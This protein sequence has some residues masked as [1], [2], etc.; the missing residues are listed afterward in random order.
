MNKLIKLLN[1]LK[2]PQK[3]VQVD[4]L[5]DYLAL[6]K[7]KREKWG[8]WYIQPYALPS[9][10]FDDAETGTWEDFEEYLRKEYPIQSFIREVMPK[11]FYPIQRYYHDYKWKIYYLFHPQHSELH[12]TIAREWRDL[13]GIIPDFLFACIKSYVEKEL[14]GK[15]PHHDIKKASKFEKSLLIN[16]NKFYNELK[17]CYQYI[18]IERLELEKL[19]SEELRRCSENKDKSLSYYKKYKSY[20]LIERK[21]KYYDDKWLTWI[22]KFRDCLW[23]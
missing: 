21:L 4:N 7:E 14:N 3:Y 20:I 17:K 1:T 9:K 22:V 10:F 15:I 6:P 2:N 13:T 12:K 11:W 16:E 8:F 19:E 23:I 18:T 5:N